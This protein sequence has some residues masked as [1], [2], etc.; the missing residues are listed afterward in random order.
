M[1]LFMMNNSNPQ[2]YGWGFLFMDIFII[3]KII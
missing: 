3:K 2:S 1:A